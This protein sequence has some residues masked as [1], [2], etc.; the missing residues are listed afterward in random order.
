MASSQEVGGRLYLTVVGG[1]NLASQRPVQGSID[2]YCIISGGR[3]KYKTQVQEK[4]NSPQWNEDFQ[5]NVL[6]PFTKLEVSVWSHGSEDFLGKVVLPLV[7]YSEDAAA[8]NWF[9]LQPRSEADTSVTGDIELKLQY[10]YVR[11]W[12]I[13]YQGM[14][15]MKRQDWRGALQSL[16]RAIDQFPDEENLYSSR[17]AVCVEL[18]MSQ[19]A[20]ADAQKL[21]NLNPNSAEGYYRTGMVY[22][23]EEEYLHAEE[24]FLKALRF[25]SRDSRVKSA[26][27]DIK[28]RSTKH[29]VREAIANGK[30]AFTERGD[31]NTAIK[32]FTDA[33]EGNPHNCAL[34]TYRATAYMALGKLEEAALDA[35]KIVQINPDWPKS[36]STKSGYLE[37]KGKINVM[38][39]RR[40]FVMKHYFLYYYNT[41]KDA[42]PNG[43]VVLANFRLKRRRGKGFA[44][45]TPGRAYELRADSELES[46]AWVDVLQSVSGPRFILPVDKSDS[47]IYFRTAQDRT[48]T[49]TKIN[50]L[51]LANSVQRKFNSAMTTITLQNPDCMG[52][53]EKSGE[54]SDVFQRRWFILKMKTLFYFVDQQ[55]P[56]PRN[57][58]PKGQIALEG[59]HFQTISELG[60]QFSIVTP[61]RTFQLRADNAEEYAKWKNKLLPV[62]PETQVREE[63]LEENEEAEG[64]GENAA[65]KQKEKRQQEF[66]DGS[67]ASASPRRSFFMDVQS[68]GAE[69][70]QQ[71]QSSARSKWGSQ[72]ESVIDS[73]PQQYKP[74]RE[75]TGG[76]SLEDLINHSSSSSA[77]TASSRGRRGNDIS[78][79]ENRYFQRFGLN[80]PMSSDVET[81]NPFGS[82]S[83]L[84]SSS[85]GGSHHSLKDL[86]NLGGVDIETP[87]LGD[88]HYHQ[89]QD[90][91]CSHCLLC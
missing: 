83:S 77:Y 47:V 10:K 85:G 64:A 23:A 22:M 49:Y 75:D 58:T 6:E 21:I 40:W 24:E 17:S 71:Q 45:K 13:L 43:V 62:C 70:Q 72:Q 80:S 84:L 20:L 61:D 41:E 88:H 19:E 26:L 46:D 14:Q 11:E 78:S 81:V 66:F 67:A 68:K 57:V 90:G 39:R 87:L 63:T 60:H 79:S 33:L 28:H 86:S 69:S 16:T 89:K 37:K 44:L 73:S 59:A 8:Q 65:G 34:Y 5:I 27:D 36:E 51:K 4:T 2:P 32:H 74:Q 55:E 29:R 31:Y 7:D 76:S 91:C 35:M 42:E 18:K 50:P 15:Q 1:R 56:N 38:M 12:E 9:T 52:W 25:N 53:L 30:A 3:E 54:Y 48:S 82:S